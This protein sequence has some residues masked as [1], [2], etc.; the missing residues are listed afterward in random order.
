MKLFNVKLGNE[1]ILGRAIVSD[2]MCI[3]DVADM[4]M[5]WNYYLSPSKKT[6]KFYD[7]NNNFLGTVIER[8][9]DPIVNAYAE[10]YNAMG[11]NIT[12]GK[13]FNINIK[14]K[15]LSISRYAIMQDMRY[16]QL[17]FMCETIL[18]SKREIIENISYNNISLLYNIAKL[19]MDFMKYKSYNHITNE[20]LDLIN[21]CIKFLWSVGIYDG[22]KFDNN[23]YIIIDHRNDRYDMYVYDSFGTESDAIV[24][25][26]GEKIYNSNCITGESVDLYSD[27]VYS[28][29]LFYDKSNKIS[30]RVINISELSSIKIYHT[31]KQY[32]EKYNIKLD[33]KHTR[34]YI[35]DIDNDSKT[36][37]VDPV[38][39]RYE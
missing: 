17:Y 34:Q 26:F 25:L 5:N 9:L 16:G 37:Y 30:F 15:K 28:G 39:I 13:R 8:K 11:Y 1:C 3:D 6:N 7:I 35:Y 24:G 10:Y 32:R 23:S 2:N 21:S 20:T 31:I 18:A 4:Y 14:D 36:F 38:T 22:A 33:I 27:E 29:V 12:V 19:I